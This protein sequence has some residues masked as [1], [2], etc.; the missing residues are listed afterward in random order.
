MNQEPGNP[1]VTK[2]LLRQ[3]IGSFRLVIA[4]FTVTSAVTKVLYDHFLPELQDLDTIRWTIISLGVLLFISTLFRFK[5]RII[6]PYFALFLYLATLLYVI[7]FVTINR[8][9]PNT[10]I[11]L[12]LVYGASSV[13]INSLFYYG[14]QCV[15]TV[16]TCVGAYSS[17]GPENINHIGF[18][19]ILIAMGVFGIVMTI[20]LK[21]ISDV[22]NSYSNL[23]K[24]NVLS[25]V[26]NKSGQ[27]VFVS[28]S[29]K[30]L[31]GY[32]PDELMKDGWW[33]SKNLRDGW[34][35]RDQ[36]LALPNIIPE[37]ILSMETSL[38][39]KDG[40]K[41]WFNWVNSMLPNGNYM[42]VALDITKYKNS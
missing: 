26:A 12:I 6:V 29:V 23:E 28:P 34:I 30:S 38:V 13:I 41:L 2:V 39:T 4:L 22:K 25:I 42:G 35:S 33:S 14:V 20:R 27:I 11:I 8:F 32:S 15:I 37:D 16:L 7:A 5:R 17:I 3:S 24:L 31:L 9:D 1:F 21:L 19:N 40:K 36:I 18:L 10:V